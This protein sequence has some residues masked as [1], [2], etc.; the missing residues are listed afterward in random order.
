MEVAPTPGSSPASGMP[1]WPPVSSSPKPAPLLSKA[2]DLSHR[3]VS[4]AHAHRLPG[5]PSFSAK[6]SN[7]WS[8][9]AVQQIKDLALLSLWYRLDPWPWNF[10]R[11]WVWPKK[12]PSLWCCRLSH[13]LNEMQV[14]TLFWQNDHVGPAFAASHQEAQIQVAPPLLKLIYPWFGSGSHQF[15]SSAGE[16]NK[17]VTL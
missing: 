17:Q 10:Q 9:L 13:I 3:V 16:A 6:K 2:C 15:F 11:P 1:L 8:S 5:G 14:K 4:A 7:H 12:N